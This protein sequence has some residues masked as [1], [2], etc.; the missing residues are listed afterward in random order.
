[1]N[2]G[3]LDARCALPRCAMIGG[4]WTSPIEQWALGAVEETL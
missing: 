2:I 3:M 4:H 1:M